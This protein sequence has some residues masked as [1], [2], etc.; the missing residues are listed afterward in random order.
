M[1]TNVTAAMKSRITRFGEEDPAQLLANPLNFRRHSGV[2]QEAMT[3]ILEDV[4]FVQSVIVNERTGHVIDGHMRVEVAMRNHQPTVPVTYVDLSDEEERVVLATFD[5]ISG[6]A[7]MDR[8]ALRSLLDDTPHDDDRTDGLFRQLS[9]MATPAAETDWLQKY[10]SPAKQNT[11]NGGQKTAAP[12]PVARDDDDDEDDD[13]D[14]PAAS[15]TPA[16]TPATAHPDPDEFEVEPYVVMNFTLPAADRPVVL[17]ALSDAR[18]GD[19]TLTTGDALVIIAR[20][21]VG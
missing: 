9:R 18:N 10:K 6:M 12:E 14:T 7:H 1:D 13:D 2:Q 5:P 16:P 20:H 17:K 3:S 4:G 11:H 19:H 15:P 8:D 21:Y